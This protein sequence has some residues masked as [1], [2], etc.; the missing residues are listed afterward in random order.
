M[1]CSLLFLLVKTDNVLVTTLDR[2]GA[3]NTHPSLE[4]NEDETAGQ[5]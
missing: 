4:Q 5:E 2:V 1:S 3:S